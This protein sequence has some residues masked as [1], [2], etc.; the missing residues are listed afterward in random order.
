[1]PVTFQE[2]RLGSLNSLGAQVALPATYTINIWVKNVTLPGQEWSNL[3]LQNSGSKYVL[4][5]N[6]GAIGTGTAPR[7]AAGAS[8][9]LQVAGTWHLVSAVYNGSTMEYYVNGV[10]IGS[11]TPASPPSVIDVLNGPAGQEFAAEVKDMRVYSGVAT[12]GE[13]LAS[14]NNGDGDLLPLTLTDSLVAKYALDDATD[15]VSSND[16]SASGTVSYDLDGN[17]KTALFSSGELVSANTI[18]LTGQA[19]VSFWAKAGTSYNYSGNNYESFFRWGTHAGSHFD[20]YLLNGKIRALHNAGNGW[21]DNRGSVAVPAGWNHYAITIDPSN[22]SKIV[23]LNGV[24]QALTG[25]AFSGTFAASQQI[26]LGNISTQ[27]PF[28]SNGGRMDD[29]RIWTRVLSASEIAGLHAAGAEPY[30]PLTLADGLVAKYDLDYNADDSVGTSNGTASNITFAAD[31]AKRHAVFERDNSATISVP[32]G[33]ATAITG[34]HTISAW[35]RLETINGYYTILTA[36]Q[37]GLGLIHG[38]PGFLSGGG[39]LT[40]NNAL[41]ALNTNTWYHIAMTKSGS[42]KT[43]YVNGSAQAN[44]TDTS[45]SWGFGSNVQIGRGSWADGANGYLDGDMD[46]HRVWSRALSASEISSLYAAGLTLTDGLV[47]KYN[48]NADGSPSV[49]SETFTAANGVSHSGNAAAFPNQNSAYY[50]NNPIALGTTYTM[51]FWFENLK[52]RSAAQANFLMATG[53]NKRSNGTGGYASWDKECGF[54]VTVY[55]NDYLGSYGW[56]TQNSG[57]NT[58]NSTGFQMTAANYRGTG[59]HHLMCVLDGGQMTY[60]VNGVKAGNSITYIGQFKLQNIG[61]WTDHNYAFADKMDD[62]R[63]WNR[64]LS[65][66]DAAALHAAGAEAGPTITLSDSLTSMYEL[67]ADVTD[68]EGNYNATNNGVTFA[69]DA[70]LGRDVAVFAGGDYFDIPA[71]LETGITSS[72]TLSLWIKPDATRM[73]TDVQQGLFSDHVSGSTYPS[74]QCHLGGANENGKVVIWHRHGNGSSYQE[75]WSTG[76]ITPDVWTQLVFVYSGSTMKIYINGVLDSSGA[77]TMTPWNNPTVMRVGQNSNFNHL[78]FVGS[79]SDMRFWTDRELLEDDASALYATASGS[80]YDWTHGG[81]I[82]QIKSVAIGKDDQQQHIVAYAKLGENSSTTLHF[83]PDVNTWAEF[84]TFDSAA[85]GITSTPIKIEAG[86]PGHFF[87]TTNDDKIWIINVGSAGSTCTATPV[88]GNHHVN[89]IRSDGSDTLIMCYNDG[90]IKTREG[91]AAS[92]SITQRLDLNAIVEA[93]TTVWDMAKGHDGWTIVARRPDDSPE[94]LLIS[95]DWSTI[96]SGNQLN[97]GIADVR[98]FQYAEWNNTW[99]A[100]N[101][102]E[103][104]STSDLSNWHF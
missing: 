96:H 6:Y 74:I 67:T 24:A 37:E 64:A 83:T 40:F 101:G 103:T 46:D 30:V 94:V 87:L 60:Y 53:H 48:L 47:A 50:T 52:D 41:S 42:T 18:D 2:H 72:Y 43:L 75:H 26:W 104:V 29:T 23:Y 12:A 22:G 70:S 84:E 13:I 31:G 39:T 17:Q 33:V 49:G 56:A 59:W 79:M 69:N 61:S 19:T 10:S 20:L 32:S 44:G 1:M 95:L 93:G 35:L 11:I 62:F 91:A 38:K 81:N 80:S 3:Y 9:P 28:R 58:T 89:A 65:A 16:L 77:M 68:S 36:N 54:D 51:S 99:Y 34:D 100:S 92:G 66:S 90:T 63:V 57:A 85:T 55:S 45:T 25:A 5:A 88:D 78:S 76:S 8:S 102:T 14:F 27:T 71:G 86:G 82:T 21:V 4:D 15:S 97:I 7:L 98:E 73:S